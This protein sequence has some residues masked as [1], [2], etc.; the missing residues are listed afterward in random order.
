MTKM[1]AIHSNRG[2]VGK[3]VIAVN[4][5]IAYASLGQNVCLLDLDFRAPSISKTLQMQ[6]PKLWMND[7]LDGRVDFGDV[8]VDVTSKYQT[9]GKLLV[10]L[11]DTS[12][13]S[14]RDMASKD[15]KWEMNALRKLLSIRKVLAEDGVD[16]VIFDT[17]PGMLYA[18]VNAVACSDIVVIVTT[19][20]MIATQETQWV[21]NELYTAFEKT[22]YV[23]VNK[24]IPTH[25][26]NETERN[27]ISES[28]MSLF[29]APILSVV[30]CYCDLLSSRMMIYTR[31]LPEHPFSKA[32]YDAAKT[33]SWIQT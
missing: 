30:P 8:L 32:I 23:F 33:L 19:A 15:K 16:Y 27:R 31:E 25:Q 26:C 12:L 5:A 22:A 1:I 11:A 21:I 4:L 29:S 10:G 28:L 9:E 17:S 14:I 3:T 24:A 20:D 2:G 6:Y 18:S 13:G 7:F